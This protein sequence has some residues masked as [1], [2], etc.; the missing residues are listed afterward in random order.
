MPSITSRPP[1]LAPAFTARAN[2]SLTAFEINSRPQNNLLQMF[3][4]D[5]FLR[6]TFVLVFKFCW[7]IV[8]VT[9]LTFE[10]GIS[11]FIAESSYSFDIDHHRITRFNRGC[12]AMHISFGWLWH[13]LMNKTRMNVD[14][15]VLDRGALYFTEHFAIWQTLVINRWIGNWV[16]GP[17]DGR[18]WQLYGRVWVQTKENV[19][20]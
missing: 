13:A 11:V 12:F 3:Q 8:N 15:R 20:Q 5:T 7:V 17:L 18:V 10:R 1:I 4:V 14:S 19:N 16:Y 9:C 6:G 2:F